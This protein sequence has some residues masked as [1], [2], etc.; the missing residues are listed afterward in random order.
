MKTQRNT[1]FLAS[2]P[3]RIVFRTVNVRRFTQMHRHRR[4]DNTFVSVSNRPFYFT[5]SR[6]NRRERDNTLRDEAVAK[7][8][9]FIK[10]PVVVSPHAGKL[11]RRVSDRPKNFSGETSQCWIENAVVNAVCVHRL[12]TR[13]WSVGY[14]RGLFPLF[15][16][17]HSIHHDG[18]DLSNFRQRK[19]TSIY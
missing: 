5:N 19:F 3:N 8:H 1:Q 4:K 12:Q 16:G 14:F 6:I 15:R 2:L 7:A 18:T 10:E 9:P 17:I 11:E 13:S